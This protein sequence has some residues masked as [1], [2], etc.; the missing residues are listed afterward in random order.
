MKNRSENIGMDANEKRKCVR[1][2]PQTGNQL[3]FVYDFESS[4]QIELNEP[5][6]EQKHIYKG[7]A[8]NI[9]ADGICIHS[10]YQLN[11]GKTV[12]I[13]YFL[14]GEEKSIH[15]KGEVRWSKIISDAVEDTS[16]FDAGLRL[17][18][19]EGESVQ[20]SIY[21]DDE[22]HVYWSNVLESVLG[23]YRIMRQGE[24]KSAD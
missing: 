5:N 4:I 24:N 23:R 18:S 6:N 10:D 9:S 13:E 16:G 12:E 20:Q 8:K 1:L 17:I 3:N 22:Y 19:V 11:I 2:E 14:P 15:M 7:I 21:F